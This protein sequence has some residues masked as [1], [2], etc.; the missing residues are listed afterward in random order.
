MAK[1]YHKVPRGKSTDEGH[2]KC[3]AAGRSPAGELAGEIKDHVPRRRPPHP[4][5]TPG[6]APGGGL[7]CGKGVLP[8]HIG[9][10]LLLPLLQLAQGCPGWQTFLSMSFWVL[11]VVQKH[12]HYTHTH[13]I[14][15]RAIDMG[16]TNGHCGK[17]VKTID[18]GNIHISAERDKTLH[19]LGRFFFPIL[20]LF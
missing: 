20:Q 2:P 13:K 1:I 3:S 11:W 4:S 5:N 15:Q 17:I 6:P 8:A 7:A 12:T 10:L 18:I 16:E 9:I 19:L 14:Y